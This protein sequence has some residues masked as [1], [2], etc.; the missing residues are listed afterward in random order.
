MSLPD[1]Q[2]VNEEWPAVLA[3]RFH[4]LAMQFDRTMR[5]SKLWRDFKRKC[6]SAN[7]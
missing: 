3:S 7:N 2:T 1:A 6:R 5:Q 4:G